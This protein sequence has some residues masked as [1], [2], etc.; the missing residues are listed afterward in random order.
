MEVSEV[1]EE[2]IK[3]KDWWEMWMR[4]MRLMVFG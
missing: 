4:R 3:K 2:I 1:K